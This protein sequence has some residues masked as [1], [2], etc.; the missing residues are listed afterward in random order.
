METT[1]P[2]V[3][4]LVLSPP[5][6]CGH[7]VNG[8]KFHSFRKVN[9]RL[10]MLKVL[11]FVGF[12]TLTAP[13]CASQYLSV[14][15]ALFPCVYETYLLSFLRGV[16]QVEQADFRGASI[17]ASTKASSVR[18]ALSNIQFD[19]FVLPLSCRASD[20]FSLFILLAFRFLFPSP[21]QLH[22]TY[23]SVH[24]FF[25]LSLASRK[26]R[27]TMLL[28]ITHKSSRVGRCG[29]HRTEFADAMNCDG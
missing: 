28:K 4:P 18:L 10:L 27:L 23:L 3:S 26:S 6:H 21:P 29:L 1:E 7:L 11:S 13:Y 12:E 25:L 15:N 14:W 24:H 2:E 22:K 17:L 9:G 19:S 16:Q 8:I 5:Y 20:V